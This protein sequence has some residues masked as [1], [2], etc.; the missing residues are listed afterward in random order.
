[1]ESH[2]L[3]FCFQLLLLIHFHIILMQM[4]WNYHIYI[5]VVDA[6]FKMYNISMNGHPKR[7]LSFAISVYCHAL[8]L[9]PFSFPF[10]LR[11]KSSDVYLPFSIELIYFANSQGFYNEYAKLFWR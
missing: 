1:M 3:N 11:F 6:D 8:K 7:L 10:A 2:L 9:P 4:V 5:V